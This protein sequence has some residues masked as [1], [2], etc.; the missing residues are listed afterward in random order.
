MIVE[1]AFAQHL[2]SLYPGLHAFKDDLAW[3]QAGESWPCVLVTK[4]AER[5]DGKGTG[6]YDLRWW[7]EDAGEWVYEK[8][9]NR[10]L[11]L[12]LT[13]RSAALGTKSGATLVDEVAEAIRALLRRHATGLALDLTDTDSGAGVHLERVRG[14][15]ESDQSPQISS[16]PFEAQRTVDVELWARVVDEVQRAPVMESISQTIELN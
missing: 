14:L 6:R 2:V 16:A 4:T 13:V 10:R 9:W 8:H 5:L 15:G 3:T 11:S 1:R 7:D 12:R